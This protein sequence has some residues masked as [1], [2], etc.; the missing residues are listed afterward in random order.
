VR[1]AH[2]KDESVLLPEMVAAAKSLAAAV[3]EWCGVAA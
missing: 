2:S 3:T 1:I